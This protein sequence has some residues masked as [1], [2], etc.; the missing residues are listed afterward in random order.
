MKAV[1]LQSGYMPWLGYFDMINQADVFVFLDDV[2][3]TNTDWR[4]RNRVRTPQGWAW[5][6]VPVK[7]EKSHL[8]YYIKDV[9]IDNSQDWQ[10][11]HL[12]TIW[13]CYKKSSY[14]TEVY[15]LFDNILSKKHTL[16]A[17]LNYEL[18]FKICNYIGVKE[19]RFLFS[20]DMKIPEELKRTERLLGILNQI[21]GVTTYISGPAAKSY[22][23]EAKFEEKSI[24]V[25]WHDYHHPYYNQNTWRSNTF[26]SHLSIIDLLFNHGKESF[27]ILSCQKAIEK[28]E[29]IQIIMP[30]E[31]M[32][33][34]KLLRKVLE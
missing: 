24:K 13:A 17:D 31:Y 14:F 10:K 30:D 32:V 8:E 15:P 7:F 27:E 1:V 6:T 21:R 33:K 12:D 11:R 25:E 3:W 20:Q 2:Q 19:T 9:K 29:Q 28:P 18:I 16:V 5:L 22:L 34:K 26:I 4:N 23:E